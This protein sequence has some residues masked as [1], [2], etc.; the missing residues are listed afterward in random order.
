[1]KTF[2]VNPDLT[3]DQNDQVNAENKVQFFTNA[4]KEYDWGWTKE[5]AVNIGSIDNGYIWRFVEV[6]DEYHARMQMGRYGSG[7]FACYTYEEWNEQ[8]E[9]KIPEGFVDNSFRHDLMPSFFKAIK[10][11][12]TGLRIW[13][14]SKHGTDNPTEAEEMGMKQFM[15]EWVDLDSGENGIEIIQTDNWEEI[16]T[17]INN[18]KRTAYV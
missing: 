15:L 13:V 12:D 1:M 8:F 11:E 16:L 7:M 17:A 3:I 9:N 10:N 6:E 4:P 2:N 18:F 5:I 14:D